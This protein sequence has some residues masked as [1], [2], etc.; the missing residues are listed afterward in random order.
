MASPS[1]KEKSD[2]AITLLSHPSTGV[3][4]KAS[5]VQ[6]R[7]MKEYG[8]MNA[9]K[10]EDVSSC[11]YSDGNSSNDDPQWYLIQF[12]RPIQP[13]QLKLQ[14]QAGFAAETCHIQIQQQSSSPTTKD[15]ESWQEVEP[16]D[17]HDVQSF[18]LTKEDAKESTTK[19]IKLV[20]GDF[21]DFYGRIMI[22]RIEIWGV[23]CQNNLTNKQEDS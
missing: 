14:F 15:W 18:P 10:S 3:S 20:F 23:E 2:N 11:W 5:S 16:D 9:L 8:P 22:Y 4:A 17:V 13:T 1:D 21:T 12:G 7:N 6:H 19:A